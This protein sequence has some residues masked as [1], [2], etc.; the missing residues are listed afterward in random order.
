MDIHEFE[1]LQG[2]FRYEGN[3]YIIEIPIAKFILDDEIVETIIRLGGIEL[4][5]VLSSYV[6]RSIAFPVNPEEGYIDGSIYLRHA[7]N[8]VD[9]HEISFLGINN[10]CLAV[11]LDAEFLFEFENIG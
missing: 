11:E 2:S 5:E 10:N 8:P 4:A 1:F 6:G 3:N 9:V 7:H